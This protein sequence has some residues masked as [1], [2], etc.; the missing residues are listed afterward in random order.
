MNTRIE[1]YFSVPTFGLGRLEKERL[2]AA[3]L[4]TLTA[5]HRANCAEYDKILSAYAPGF[6]PGGDLAPMLA[7]GLF[8]LRHLSSVDDDAVFKTLRSS[9]TT[10]QVPSSIVLDSDTARLQ[11]RALAAIMTSFIGKER[12]PMLLIDYPSVLRDRRNSSARGAGLLG[13]MMFG[14]DHTFALQNET[15]APDWHAIE[16]F[17]E[18]HAGKPILA[19]GFTFIVWAQ[20][21]KSLEESGRRLPFENAILVHSGGWKRMQETSVSR[22]LFNET[23]LKLAGFSRVHN[24]YGM[25]EQTGSVFVECEEGHLH[26]PIFADVIVR[27]PLD[28]S[29]QSNGVPGVIQVI[30]VLPRSYP[31]HSLLTED[32]GVLLGEDDCPC[33]R[34][35]KYFEVIGRLQK[36]EVR[37]CSDTFAPVTG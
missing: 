1:D 23:A 7:V 28:L 22:K 15:A 36:V 16:Q 18:K 13:M 29:V 20:L 31:G 17:A 19:F 26:A 34:K 11:T 24:F 21:L 2:M 10:S 5:H 4:H 9:G 27:N 25:V 3:E 14:R 35:G 32:Q 30:S 6:V 8:K 37:G 33:G 12:L